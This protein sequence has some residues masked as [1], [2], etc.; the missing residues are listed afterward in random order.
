MNKT[1]LRVGDE[2]R[3]LNYRLY[4][5][6]RIDAFYVKAALSHCTLNTPSLEHVKETGV[7]LQTVVKLRAF[8]RQTWTSDSPGIIA[9]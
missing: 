5:N 4:W 3:F 7:R 6:N 1:H 9:M 8:F 2:P